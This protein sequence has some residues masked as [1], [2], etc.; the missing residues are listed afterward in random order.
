M[1]HTTQNFK[2]LTINF[3]LLHFHRLAKITN[4]I[5]TTDLKN[6]GQMTIN[7]NK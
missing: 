5:D 7:Q 4:P 3:V 2:F 6:K 1:K